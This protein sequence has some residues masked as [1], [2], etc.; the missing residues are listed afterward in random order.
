MEKNIDG[1][2][3]DRSTPPVEGVPFKKQSIFFQYLPYW[4]DLEVPHAI[5]AMHVQK[6]VF[7]CL[8][9]TL[10]DTCKSKDGLKLW[11]DMV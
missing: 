2:N 8:I 9:G 6:N 5:Y 3:R 4:S 11:K 10:M 1:T 7:E